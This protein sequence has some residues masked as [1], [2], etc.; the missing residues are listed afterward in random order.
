MQYMD[1]MML[2][3][4]SERWCPYVKINKNDMLKSVLTVKE[5]LKA[6][7]VVETTRV[8]AGNE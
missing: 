3:I 5:K 4:D 2:K 1:R 6:K 8:P 7:V